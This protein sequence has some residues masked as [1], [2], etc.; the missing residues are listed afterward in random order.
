M[1]QFN[2]ICIVGLGL[3]GGSVGIAA[4]E[5]RLAKRVYGLVRR[6]ESIR[7]AKRLGVVDV[8]TMDAEEATSNADLVIIATP[9]GVME[10]MAA[11]IK[12]YL[13]PGCIVTDVGS[14]KQ[15]V[16]GL[17]EK[18]FHPCV[19]FIGAH[20]IAGSERSGMR[21]SRANLFEGAPCI[22]TPTRKTNKKSLGKVRRLWRDLGSR[23]TL[24]SP[25]AHDRVVAAISHLPHV[26]AVTLVNCI[27]GMPGSTKK[28]LP[29]AGTGFKD[30]TRI[31]ASHPEMWVDICLA[32]RKEI[33]RALESF[34][35]QLR[36]LK[37][38]LRSAKPPAVHKHL[39]RASTTRRRIR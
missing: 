17:M 13:S 6:K 5:R 20:P 39:S 33:L 23:V 29:F 30:S 31:A 28:V 21:A 27:A 38:A 14:S 34:E 24:M 25:G 9:L 1:P 16:V 22:L 37:K 11:A 15:C 32:N 4:K 7:E 19:H 8:A 36:I 3:I 12:P 18:L 35:K 10:R 26:L 2:K